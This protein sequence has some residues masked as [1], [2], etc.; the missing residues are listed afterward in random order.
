MKSVVHIGTSDKEGGAAIAAWRLHEGMLRLGVE[1]RVVSR[2]RSW[3]GP[4]VSRISTPL[5]EAVDLFHEKR[6]IPAQRAAATLFSLS[7]VSIPLMDH[8]WI[9]AADV[10]H[11]HWVAQFLAPEDIAGLCKAGKTVF[12]TFHDQW[13]YTGGCHYVGGLARKEDDWDGRA[14]IGHAM[15]SL[16]SMEWQRKKQAFA[17]SPIH[18]IA[19]SRWMAEEAAASGVFSPERITVVPYGINTSV[20]RP[21]DP[22]GDSGKT[23]D[24]NG[25]VTLLFGCQY[26][27]ERRKGYVELRQALSRCMLDD[28]FADAVRKGEINVTTFG[29]MPEGGMDLPIPVTHLGMLAGEKEVADVLRASSAFICPTL[30]DNLPNVVMESLACE[31]PVVAFATGGVPDMVS[32]GEN[33]LLAP[34]GNVEALARHLTDFCLDSTLRKRL[35]D[36]TRNTDLADRSLETQASRILTLYE[37]ASP[38]PAAGTGRKVPDCLP[39][40]VLDAGILPH[41]ATEMTRMF[42]DEKTAQASLF[43]ARNGELDGRLANLWEQFALSQ[44][45]LVQSHQQIDQLQTQI[46]KETSDRRELRSSIKR[47]T[48][49]LEKAERRTNN[50]RIKINGLK[51]K[52]LKLKSPPKK[53][54]TL[55]RIRSFLLRRK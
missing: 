36:G 9:A 34:K 47:L 41:F 20:F 52:N 27:G 5:F 7:P 44:Q 35:R 53:K 17:D 45:Q 40:V 30:E 55:Q 24:H 19:P 51:E 3:P 50:L 32:H 29:G 46:H 10:V 26:L 38:A 22:A 39:A 11:L 31:C 49:K 6:V 18:V 12:W 54:S 42:L 25:K 43:S 37:A 14:Q 8:P 28:R 48:T 33:G 21:S 23:D 1:S 13:P 4:E 15:H 16:A 2:Y